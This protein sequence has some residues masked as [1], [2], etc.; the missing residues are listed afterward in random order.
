[1]ISPQWIAILPFWILALP[2]IVAVIAL[3][4]RERIAGF[5]PPDRRDQRGNFIADPIVK[6]GDSVI[7]KG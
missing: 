4:R 2:L 6:A 5:I 1:M 3:F 7:F